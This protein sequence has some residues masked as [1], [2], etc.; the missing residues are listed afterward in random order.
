MTWALKGLSS[1]REQDQGNFGLEKLVSQSY[2]KLLVIF[3]DCIIEHCYFSYVPS[4]MN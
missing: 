3:L 2:R 4:S 1:A